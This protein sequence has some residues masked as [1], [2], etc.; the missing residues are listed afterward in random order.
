MPSRRDFLYAAAA[1]TAARA[2]AETPILEEAQLTDLEAGLTA[3]RF[4]SS[5]LV[6]QYTARIANIDK[7]INSVIELNPDA[8]ATAAALDRERKE[9]GPRSPLHGIPILIKD[10]IDTAD[11]MMTTAGSLAL[12]GNPAPKDAALVTRLREAGAVLLGKTNLSEWANYRSSHS[13]SGWSGRG[14]LTRNPYVLDRN[15]SGSSSGSGAAVAASLCA[16]AVGTET[17]G[18][19][20]SPSSMCGIVGIKPTLGLI[21]GAGI[22]PISH[23]QDTAGP[24]ARTV[25]DAALLLGAL[26][27]AT[28]GPALDPKGLRGARIGVARQLFGFND[29]VDKMMIDVLEVLTDL[30]AQLVDP[31]NIATYPKLSDM[32]NEA[33]SW[34]FKND[35]NAYL[36]ARGGAMRTLADLIIF[37]ER[38]RAREMRYFD[39]DLF[40]KAEARGPLSTRAYRELEQKLSRAAKGEGIDRVMIEHKLDALVAPTDSPAWPTDYVL[41]DH[42]VAT[43]STP[44]AVAGYPHVT[45]PA[46]QIYGLPVGLSFFGSPRTEVRLIRYAYAFEQGTNARKPPQYLPTVK[47]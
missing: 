30:G 44:A 3:G 2:S 18:S 5:A 28:Y 31:V 14:G 26:T 13:I 37:N 46:G 20:V 38:N 24:M 29:L 15:T 32:E 43:T 35:I 45:V 8:P 7:K 11:K 9:K 17:D 39:Q 23:R 12:A 22:V 34:E 1:L 41:G 27:R 16:A 21:P 6:E 33:M 42:S 10:N 19:V 36:A 25:T 40:I 4:T 47:L